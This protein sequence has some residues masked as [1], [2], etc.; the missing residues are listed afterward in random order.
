MGLSLK[1][2]YSLINGL[3]NNWKELNSCPKIFIVLK[4]YIEYCGVDIKHDNHNLHGK[5]I[6]S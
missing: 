3:G 2:N 1:R 4:M 6:D 5:L